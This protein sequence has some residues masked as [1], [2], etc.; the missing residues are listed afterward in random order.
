MRAGAPFSVGLDV[1]LTYSTHGGIAKYIRRL[2]SALPQ[3]DPQRRHVHFYRRGHRETFSPLAHRVDCWTPAHHWLEPIALSAEVSRHRPAL[4]HSPDFIPPLW[5][6][7]RSVITVHDLTFLSHPEFLTGESRRYYNGQIRMAVKLAHAISAD[8]HATK[9]DLVNRLSVI[10][11]KIT[12]IHLGLDEAFHVLPPEEAAPALAR[13]GLSPGY[14]LFVGTFE[15]RKN[16]P[17]LFAGYFRLRKLTPDAP[18]LVLV[19]HRGWLFDATISLMRDL[20][21]EQHVRFFENLPAA[22]LPAVYNGASAFVLPSHYEGFG[23]PVL[24]AM[25][26]GVPAIISNR[27]S[28]PEIGGE[29]ALTVDPDDPDALADALRR[30]LADSALRE[31]MRAKGLEQVKRFTWE[32]T[33]QKT[34]E[35]YNQVL[36]E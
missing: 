33:V 36:G 6:Y 22:D 5:G 19:G 13:L 21:L 26:C 2:A 17:G 32:K 20:G 14:L 16:V 9:A 25:G 35:L 15:P 34:L 23:F 31:S 7:Q 27:A 24:E 28:L 18:P 1:R 8:S 11:E 4:L 29:A 12:V 3:R 10:P 30:V